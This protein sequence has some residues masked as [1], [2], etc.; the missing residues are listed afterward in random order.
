MNL[1]S[2]ILAAKVYSHSYHQQ[3]EGRI[4]YGNIRM[5]LHASKQSSVSLENGIM[6]EIKENHKAQMIDILP[7]LLQSKPS[8][9][10]QQL[11]FKD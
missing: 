9:S 1:E 2:C 8:S 6:I 5:T 11:N 10:S 3:D 7:K 4:C